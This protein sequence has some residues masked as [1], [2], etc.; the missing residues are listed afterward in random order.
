MK[1]KRLHPPPIGTPRDDRAITL[2]KRLIP[3]LPSWLNPPASEKHWMMLWAAIGEELAEKEPE[4]RFP[5]G[6]PP[7]S[8]NKQPMPYVK[9]TPDAKRKRP[10]AAADIIRMMVRKNNRP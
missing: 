5:L 4:F 10:N 6:R 1:R 9:L 2:A 7:G 3:D 8:R